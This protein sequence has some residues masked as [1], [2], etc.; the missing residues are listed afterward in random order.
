MAA[1]SLRNW[2]SC[3]FDLLEEGSDAEPPLEAPTSSPSGVDDDG[4][5]PEDLD[6]LQ[7]GFIEEESDSE[8]EASR[9]STR[10]K[11]KPTSP[12]VKTSK[13]GMSK[14][15]KSAKF[16]GAAPRKLGRPKPFSKS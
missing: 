12:L 16:K 10:A 9:P 7:T 15:G 5:E 14:L 11:P 2:T 6:F 3:R 4:D 8:V 1:A 13:L